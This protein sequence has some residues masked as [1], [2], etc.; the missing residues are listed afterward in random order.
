MAD[1]AELHID[2]RISKHDQLI[3]I[4]D[5]KTSKN[6][7]IYQSG[8]GMSIERDGEEGKERKEDERHND[9]TEGIKRNLDCIK[10]GTIVEGQ[11]RKVRPGS[12]IIK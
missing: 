1:M 11:I 8:D 10:E 7:R 3:R 9:N 4:N 2:K 12:F 5:K 6:D